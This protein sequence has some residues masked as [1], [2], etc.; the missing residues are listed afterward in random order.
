[1]NN[2]SKSLLIGLLENESKTIAF[3]GGGFKPPTKGHYKVVK[4]TL[5][6]HPEITKLYV[7]KF[8]A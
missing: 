5:Q 1:M 3:Y 4:K 7:A 6:D 8:L 2:L